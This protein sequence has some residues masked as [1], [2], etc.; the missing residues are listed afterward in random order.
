MNS[1][2]ADALK[3]ALYMGA[4][5]I[6]KSTSDHTVFAAHKLGRNIPGWYVEGFSDYEDKLHYF[7]WLKKRGYCAVQ[8]VDFV[9]VYEP[10][11]PKEETPG[12]NISLPLWTNEQKRTTGMLQRLV[13]A[14]DSETTVLAWLECGERASSHVVYNT[15]L[16]E[17]LCFRME[18]DFDSSHVQAIVNTLV[19]HDNLHR[20]YKSEY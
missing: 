1:K 6:G 4:E 13:I 20:L 18:K 9:F 7:G 8:G 14:Y 2:I 11:T 15:K 10:T 19:E 16:T 3:M 17:T 5:S 12:I